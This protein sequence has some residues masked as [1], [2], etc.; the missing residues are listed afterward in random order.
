MRLDAAIKLSAQRWAEV[1]KTCWKV[2][3]K[4]G[5]KPMYGLLAHPP[6]PWSR[7]TDWIAIVPKL[8]AEH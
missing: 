2:R 5:G 1:G 4:R 7:H 3:R 8:K 6:L